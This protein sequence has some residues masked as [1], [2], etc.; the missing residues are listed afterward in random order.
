MGLENLL[1]AF[2]QLEKD[3]SDVQLIIGG[4]GPLEEELIA[5]ARELGIERK[6]HFVGFISED[7]LPLYYQ[8]ADLFV[9]ATKELEGFGLVT[10]EAMAC[11]LPVV[12]TP[13]GG[14]KEILARFDSK[15]LFQNSTPEAIAKLVLEKYHQIKNNPQ[16]WASL[17]SQSR[18]FVETNYSWE[19][20]LNSLERLFEE[21][22]DH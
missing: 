21:L 14:T 16:D 12:G 6:V 9:L 10:L 13:V 8:M 1:I 18:Q 20:N 19:E 3:T 5:L 4:T 15:F 2:Q 22:I 17:C 7:R 11:G